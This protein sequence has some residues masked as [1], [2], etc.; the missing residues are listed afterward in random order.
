MAIHQTTITEPKA[1]PR[2]V[3][4]TIPDSRFNPEGFY[5]PDGLHHGTSNV[6]HSYLLT[7]DPFRFDAQFFGIKPVEANSLDPQQRLVL[8]TVYEGLE[9]AGLAINGLHGS[10]TAVYVGVMG[11]DYADM[12]NRDPDSFPTYFATGTARSILS[13]RVSYFF[14]WHGPPMTIDTACSPSLVA[15]HLA[16]PTSPRGHGVIPPNLLFK[17]L[18]PAIA[19]FYGR[20]KIP[21]HAL[22][23]PNTNGAP[24]RVSVNSFGF[25]G[26]N[27]HA[28]IE[29]YRP[30]TESTNNRDTTVFTPFTFSAA[31]ER[32]LIA[33]LKAYSLYLADHPTANL[34][35]LAWTLNGRRSVLPSRITFAATSIPSLISQVN[36]AISASQ[37]NPNK[38]IDGGGSRSTASPKPS[39]LG[40]FTG[41]GAQ[42][43]GM[44]RALILGS[45]F[46]QTLIA[47][48][49]DRLA[50]LPPADRPPWS[51]VQE[52]LADS[53]KSRL[54]EATLSQPLCTAI[55]LVVV[56]L[57]RSAGIRFGAVVGH[58]SGEIAAA[59]AAGAVA[60]PEDAICIAYYRG[61]H[62]K[63]ASGATG[64]KGAMLAVRTSLEDAQELCELPVF[65]GRISV[66][67]S[68]SP[69][70]VTLSGDENAINH[71]K[72]VFEEE[73]KFARVLRVDKAYH[74]HHMLRCSEAYLTSRATAGI[75][76]FKQPDSGTAW[77]SS[78]TVKQIQSTN[79]LSST[80]WNDNMVEPVLFSQAVE[81]AVTAGSP[82]D[83]AIE[84]GPHPALQGP[85]K[86][87]IEAVSGVV[88]PY[89]GTLQRNS[90]DIEALSSSLAYIW[91]TFGATAVDFAGSVSAAFSYD[92]AQGGNSTDLA[93]NTRGKVHFE[94]GEAAV[95]DL[96]LRGPE[97]FN[98]VDLSAER[99]YSFL[100]ETGYRY[101]GPF[102]QLSDLKRLLGTAIVTSSAQAAIQGDVEIF[103]GD[104][105]RLIL[106]VEGLH[107]KPFSDATPNNDFHLFSEIVWGNA[108]PDGHAAAQEKRASL[109]AY[110]LAYAFER[111]A[112]YYFR[113]LDEAIPRQSRKSHVLS[114][115]DKGKHQYI[116]KQW[117]TDTHDQILDLIA[118]YPESID[119]R[120]MRAVGENLPDVIRGKTIILEHMLKDNMLNEYYVNALGF[121]EYT[122]ISCSHGAGTGGATKS[123]LKEIGTTYATYT[124]T[125]IS[126]GFFENAQAVF[127][128]HSSKMTFRTLNIEKSPG[129]QGYAPQS[130]DLI[131][132]SLV[133]HATEKLE[134]TLQNVRQILKPGGTLILLE[135]TN[136]GPA[137][138]GFV[139]GGLPGWWLGHDDKRIFSPCITTPEWD[140]AFRR[141]GFSGVD[142]VTPDLDPLP[143]PLSVIVIQ[144]TDDRI[145]FLRQ[146]LLT[147]SPD[148][149]IPN[150]TILGG[151]TS[152]SLRLVGEIIGISS[153]YVDKIN[154]SDSLESVAEAYIP[155]QG[156]VLGLI[157]L[158]EPVLSSV[159]AERIDA[160]KQLFSRSKSVLWVTRGSRDDSPRSNMTVGLGRTLLLELPH[161]G[162]QFLDLG[163]TDKTDARTIT[164]ALLRFEAANAW[165]KN[166]ADLG[167]LWSVEPEIA[168]DQGTEVVP[169][170]K[171]NSKRNARYNSAKRPISK[172][173]SSEGSILDISL[174]RNQ[175]VIRECPAWVQRLSAA[176]DSDSEGFIAVDVVSSTLQAVRIAPGHYAYVVVGYNAR[177]GH[178]VTASTHQA[179]R[180]QVPKTQLWPLEVQGNGGE[181]DGLWLLV[182]RLLAE[183]VLTDVPTGEA[184]VVLDASEELRHSLSSALER[185]ETRL[186]FLT[187]DPT[188]GASGIFIH[189]QAPARNIQSTLPE[190]VY[191]FV[192]LSTQE[193][194]SRRISELIPSHAR[195]ESFKTLLSQTPRP[196]TTATQ[197]GLGAVLDKLPKHRK[198]LTVLSEG[199]DVV[200]LDNFPLQALGA[201]QLKL[202]K[203]HSPHPVPVVLNRLTLVLFSD[204]I[205]HTGWW[206]SP[207]AWDN[208]YA[209]G[210]FNMAR[211]TSFF[212]AVTLRLKIDGWHPCHRKGQL[213]RSYLSKPLFSE[214]LYLVSYIFLAKLRVML[215]I[216]T[217]E[218]Q[219]RFATLDH[220]ADDLGI[221]SLVAVEIRT[222]FLKELSVDVPVLKILGGS[223]LGE[224]LEFALEKLLA[225]LV[226]NLGAEIDLAV[227]TAK[228][229]EVQPILDN[230]SPSEPEKV[231]VKAPEPVPFFREEASLPAIPVT[232][233]PTVL[234]LVETHAVTTSSSE[235]V[236]HR[237]DSP[238]QVV[239]TPEES[240]DSVSESELQGFA[241]TQIQRTLKASFGQWRFWFLR[242][243]LEDKTTFN[244]TCSIDLSGDLRI[245]ALKR[246]V[247]L[248]GERHEALRTAFILGE[249]QQ[250]QQDILSTS[251]L[252]LETRPITSG[253]DIHTE[254]GELKNHVYDLEK[255]KLIRIRLLSLS[256]SSHHLLYGDFSTRQYKEYESGKFKAD[257]A[258]WRNEFST[259]PD[260]LPILP[261][262]SKLSRPPVIG[263]KFER[264]D[265]SLDEELAA[266]IQTVSRKLKATTFHFYL[267]DLNV[268]LYRYTDVDDL[269]IGIAD[270]NRTDA[271]T[272]SSVGFYLNL[273]ALCFKPTSTQPF[274][275]ALTEAKKKAYAALAH[276]R[277]PID[278]VL[279]ELSAPRSAAY[280][281]LFQVFLN[282]RQGVEQNRRFCGCE[283]DGLRIILSHSSTT[284]L[285]TDLQLSSGTR[286]IDV[287]AVP[288]STSRSISNN[289][290]TDSIAALV[291][292]SGST[293][294]P[295]GIQV[296]HAGF[297]QQMMGSSHMFGLHADIVLQQ[298]AVSFDISIWQT[299][300]AIANAGRLVT[301]SKAAR[302]D[303]AAL[304]DLILSEGVNVVAATPSELT[305]WHLGMKK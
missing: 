283:T 291:Y 43:A 217:E 267:A 166:G 88:I 91:K 241:T 186:L 238:F 181:L 61:L 101:S 172:P 131:I 287:Q 261:V 245:D 16:S 49:E 240:W 100:D 296:T 109:E 290:K 56:E 250:L 68:N 2:D 178:V 174:D 280:S 29:E 271:D 42:W 128:D 45:K 279:S 103:T 214:S 276:G 35:D 31:T 28:I 34:G 27:A 98:L 210:W 237:A 285:V 269:S 222:W 230:S 117:A 293:G 120:I 11:G 94:I 77:F 141:T 295:K 234:P 300:F 259:L 190:D 84:V 78:V 71:A 50:R 231:T 284:A 93:L 256:S 90:D 72:D 127:E 70:S 183:T 115:V 22:D 179:S 251:P 147:R 200:S 41:Q 80:Y 301:A 112:Y 116:K 194:L 85:A 129:A 233:A 124:F 51:L 89:S 203:W 30:A 253:N 286:V 158:D 74:S 265:L 297:L 169:R 294:V 211:V 304:I 3:L 97:T 154:R 39:I 173:V 298:G 255:G 62:S 236:S 38:R 81:L 167:A 66:A 118:R 224:L 25:G 53:S 292:T 189:P 257:L 76:R 126:S 121:R 208:L 202:I 134:Q 123:I 227:A 272:Q 193:S 243:Y 268:L 216:S 175:F 248:L 262:S 132:A 9:S 163:K 69:A 107:A 258:Y 104:N 122:A 242:E 305:T 213:L 143:Y 303:A 64:Q 274:V 152:D 19:P 57:V 192:D 151:T 168:F 164:E 254:F 282:F 170:L 184:V 221:D 15:L 142:T 199:S 209:R 99:F 180:L 102:R 75:Q 54:N 212:L 82:F 113:R 110:D 125:D 36:A 260:P 135:I 160:L 14:D 60:T 246:A 32:S 252:A 10:D 105:D 275:Q 23:W 96:P 159:T 232:E 197:H 156:S 7:E 165:G 4:S 150:L 273:L 8:E 155:D 48:L 264:V 144:A 149:A 244:I 188:K 13:N 263:Y 140:A 220:G 196:G 146:P 219:Q 111:V 136:N 106:Q 21:L 83:L 176:R 182:H 198:P 12:L 191:S 130:Y 157:D 177:I 46:A 58:S 207:E 171:L 247:R 153:D 95:E 215:Q 185:T 73:K 139:F 52:L 195:R 278:L 33:T 55:Q 63:L 114:A 79:D 223:T 229:K 239:E 277:A 289:A 266:R 249:N 92:S 299:F 86:Q 37:S 20:L 281:P 235:S 24:R 137:R 205:R 119:L 44:G 145:G 204:P 302:Q 218:A 40:I 270:G 228:L 87:T 162:L 5:H 67:A 1:H 201:S 18:N 225:T 65:E 133:L 138:L 59:Y 17:S 148:L 47:R 6:K 161:L 108:S 26:A 288:Y 206:V 226:P 187:S